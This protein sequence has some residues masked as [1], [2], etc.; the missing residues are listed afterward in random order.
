[1]NDFSLF[2]RRF[3]ADAGILELMEDLGK[4]LETPGDKI[5]LGGGNPASI[6]E[7][8][9]L[10]RRRLTE[11]LAADGEV[12]ALVAQYDAPGGRESFR[13]AAAD[14]LVRNFGWSVKPGNIVVTG[15]SQSA[16]FLLFNLL[17]GE[18]AGGRRKK[19]LFPLAPEYI[20][21]ADQGLAPGQFLS[22]RPLVTEEEA[23]YFKYH[24]DF[25]GLEAGPDIGALCAGRPTNP[26]GNVMTDAEVAHLASLARGAGVPLILDNAYGAPFPSILFE[27]AAPYWD[28]NTVLSMSLSK[29]GLPSARTGIL[30]A[31]EPLAQA[32]SSA[33]AILNLTNA[34]LGQALV[35]PLLED[36]TI[37][38]LSREIIRPFYQARRDFALGL[39]EQVFARRFAYRVHR[40]QGALFLWL[41]F[42]EL[43]IGTRELYRRLKERGVLVVPGDAFFFGLPEQDEDWEHRRQCLRINYARDP[44]EVEAGLRL[45]ADLV[46]EA[47]AP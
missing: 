3:S 32:V 12:E 42:P 41:W 33:N 10:W 26:T 14:F 37:L 46:E 24:V 39:L 7:M 19:I 13:R 11:I 1:V 44:R 9:R 23:P 35:Q 25:A 43:S 22:R 16:C 8:N 40:P 34:G 27:P 5:M 6:P 38:A 17:S 20:G 18:F 4:A 30:V 47:A 2:G 29:L 28:E 45:I 15:G 36:D 21:Y 31:P